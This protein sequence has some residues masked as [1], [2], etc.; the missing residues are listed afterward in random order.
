MSYTSRHFSPAII[1]AELARVKEPDVTTELSGENIAIKV[2]SAINEVT[3]S[4]TV[5]EQPLELTI[6]LPA[7]WPL[8]TIEIRDSKLVG[9]TEERWRAWVLGVRQIL[10]FRVR[11]PSAL[12]T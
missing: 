9:V 7:D 4:Y 2:A 12:S 3:A 1:R 6:K 11:L 10:T 8:H 5:D